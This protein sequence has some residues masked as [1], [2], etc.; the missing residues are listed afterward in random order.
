[1]WIA[2]PEVG[3]V[4]AFYIAPNCLVCLLP[5]QAQ[6]QSA[7]W[8]RRPWMR[9]MA[10]LGQFFLWCL[11]S[12]SLSSYHTLRTAG[13]LVAIISI[14]SLLRHP[15]TVHP[16]P[17]PLLSSLRLRGRKTELWITMVL[18][19]HSPTV[20]R[21]VSRMNGMPISCMVQVV[22]SWHSLSRSLQWFHDEKLMSI[23]HHDIVEM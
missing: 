2:W 16:V 4:T 3:S 13:S 19:S 6:R 5:L 20:G 12:W 8:P 10:S 14:Q 18:S 9:S 15:A 17:L 21:K 23:G 11:C 7:P 22:I 1:M